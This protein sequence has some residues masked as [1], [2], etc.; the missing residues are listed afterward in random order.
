MD[1]HYERWLH[2]YASD[3]KCSK[4]H[5]T[6]QPDCRNSILDNAYNQLDSIGR[7]GNSGPR[8][9]IFKYLN[10][11]NSLKNYRQRNP[12]TAVRPLAIFV[13]FAGRKIRGLTGRFPFHKLMASQ[14]LK[15][16]AF[17]I[18]G[19][20]F[21]KGLQSQTGCLATFC[22]AIINWRRFSWLKKNRC[23]D[24]GIFRAHSACG[25]QSPS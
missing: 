24:S 7:D 3:K 16:Q 8:C 14:K 19:P 21:I 2:S 22:E 15:K 23:P 6:K 11:S 10:R 13:L 25:M 18:I 1:L 4:F 12:R 9:P 20:L 5:A 17:R